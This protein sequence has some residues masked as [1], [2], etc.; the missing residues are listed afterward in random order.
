ML[1][2][3][4]RITVNR[5]YEAVRRILLSLDWQKKGKWEDGRFSI[6]CIR[7][8]FANLRS[9][10]MWIGVKGTAVPTGEETEVSFSVPFGFSFYL[11]VFMTLLGIYLAFLGPAPIWWDLVFL[12][13]SL[14]VVWEDVHAR[15]S[16]CNEILRALE[17]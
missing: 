10:R 5:P 6:L 15:Q 17:C 9:K 4:K 7:R 12:V 13:L 11:G 2:L 14:L 1:G 8:N 3:S 16:L